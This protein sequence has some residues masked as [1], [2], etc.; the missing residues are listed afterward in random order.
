MERLAKYLEDTKT[1]QT[2]FARLIGVS[3]PTICDWIRGDK[4]PTTENLKLVALR[5]GLSIDEL[6]GIQRRAS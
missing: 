4:S 1:S 5:T 6:L 2:E 3:Q